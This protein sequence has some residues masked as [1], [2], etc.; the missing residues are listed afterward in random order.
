MTSVLSETEERH[1]MSPAHRLVT[2]DDDTAPIP[3]VHRGHLSLGVVVDV[4]V[5]RGCPIDGTV[6]SSGEID[7]SFGTAATGVHLI[8]E[9]QALQRFVA[10]ARHLLG[11]RKRMTGDPLSRATRQDPR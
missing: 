4:D 8:F 6:N 7:F 10:L 1:G 9:P 2:N 3:I 11:P 5:P